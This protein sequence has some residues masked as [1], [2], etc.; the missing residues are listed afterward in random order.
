M[1]QLTYTQMY[2]Y[3]SAWYFT[4][5]RVSQLCLANYALFF[6]WLETHVL[7]NIIILWSH[8]MI[9]QAIHLILR[10]M[11][12]ISSSEHLKHVKK[13]LSCIQKYGI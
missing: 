2:K 13:D 4:L 8:V 12:R 9:L 10:M 7:A 5:A 3:F 6:S 11:L 1:G